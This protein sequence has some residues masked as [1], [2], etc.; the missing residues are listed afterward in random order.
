MIKHIRILYLRYLHIHKI[1]IGIK[2][3]IVGIFIT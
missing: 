1:E 3:N 2:T